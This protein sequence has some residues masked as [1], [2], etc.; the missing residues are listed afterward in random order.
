MARTGLGQRLARIVGRAARDGARALRGS[1]GRQRSAGGR[2]GPAD[3]PSGTRR[4]PE[5]SP[6]GYP[7]DFVG[8][9]EISYTPAHD[10]DPDPGEIVWTWVPFEE[11]HSRGKDRPVLVIGRDE[12]WLLALM[13]TSQDHD[14]DA[15]RRRAMAGSGSTSARARGTGRADRARPASTASS[16][17]TRPSCGARAP[18][19]RE[20]ASPR[21]PRR[22]E[23]PT[24]A[25]TRVVADPQL[26]TGRRGP[27]LGAGAVRGGPP[28]GQGPPGAAH[29]PRRQVAAGPDADEPG[30]P[31][32]RCSAARSRPTVGGDRHRPVGPGTTTEQRPRRQDHPHPP[33]DGAPR[34]CRPRPG[35]FRAGGRG[36]AGRAL[37]QGNRQPAPGTR[38]GGPVTAV[39]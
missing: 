25:G 8:V 31:V 1:E 10:G 23:R 13:L 3:T 38:A 2:P 18:C 39:R 9:P 12:S 16:A 29:R 17:S 7:G 33:Q 24:D 19:C 5:P 4:G 37:T 15:A 36:G 27:P 28:A 32:R 34:G 35:S 6:T 22:C 14:R 26:G 20:S 30:P 21:W 11:D